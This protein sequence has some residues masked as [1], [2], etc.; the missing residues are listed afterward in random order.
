MESL[1]VFGRQRPARL[2]VI[3]KVSF[4]WCNCL[5]RDVFPE[6]CNG[7]FYVIFHLDANGTIVMEVHVHAQKHMILASCHRHLP[8]LLFDP[9]YDRGYDFIVYVRYLR[10][11]DVPCDRALFVVDA[12]VGNA[13]CIIGI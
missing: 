9:L 1:P 7:L 8:E 6:I 5:L 2:V 12:F 3:E 11:I 10:V 4:C 13:S